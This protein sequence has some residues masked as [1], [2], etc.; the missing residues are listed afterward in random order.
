[1]QYVSTNAATS[2]G[3]QERAIVCEVGHQGPAQRSATRGSASCLLPRHEIVDRGRALAP[4]EA[5][6][7]VLGPPTTLMMKRAAVVALGLSQ[8]AS[9]SWCTER[10]LR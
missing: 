10:A 9:P 3:A 5:R 2:G 8:H 1:M 4:V 7:S 6:S